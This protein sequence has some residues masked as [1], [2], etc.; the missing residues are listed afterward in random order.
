MGAPDRRFCVA[1]MMGR[2]NQHYRW[3]V[4]QF[5]P[6][7]L[8]FTEMVTC[9][10]LLHM[11]PGRKR[12]RL[13]A[14][15][16]AEGQVAAQLAGADPTA[17]A[18]TA[19]LVERQGFAELNLNIGCPSNRADSGCFG[20]ALMRHPT[21]VADLVKACK[22]HTALPVTVKTRLGLNGLD[23][24][25]YLADFLGEVAQA[26]CDAFYLHARIARLDGI[27][28]AQNRSVPPLNYERAQKMR[29]LFPHLPIVVNGGITHW[30][31]VEELLTTFDG[32]MVGR[33]AYI[34]LPLLMR[35]DRALAAATPPAPD[36]DRLLHELSARLRQL[37]GEDPVRALLCHLPPLFRGMPGA[38]QIRQRLSACMGDAE[39]ALRLLPQLPWH[40]VWQ[41]AA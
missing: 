31:R 22:E 11:P 26:G 28:P 12:Q 25:S 29:L 16:A 8:L 7:L 3:L 27:K 39:A 37:H 36:P 14:H 21:L 6:N 10:A 17:F 33:A 34:D 9:N 18:A 23:S 40:R 20:A 30:Q 15:T 13:L 19:A 1:P 38:R 2:T 24:D 35:A 5:C 4:R 32:V 41:N